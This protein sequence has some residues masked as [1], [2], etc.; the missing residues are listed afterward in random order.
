MAVHTPASTAWTSAASPQHSIHPVPLPVF[1]ALEAGDLELA[2]SLTPASCPPLPPFL[3]SAANR[4]IWRWRLDSIAADPEHA[5]W[6]S[7]LVVYSENQSVN[8]D[9]NCEEVVVGRI[10]FHGKPD[11]RGAVEV[12]YEID[13]EHRRKGHAR[14]ALR[15]MIEVARTIPEVK[16]FR[17]G[18]APENFVSRRVVEGAGLRHVCREVHAWRGLQ[19][20]FEI[21][22]SK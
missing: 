15:I 8:P 22:V 10:G 11:A 12:G 3:I 16:I 14:A 7:R 9:Q 19:D 1:E 4:G 20:V 21:D 13:S 2:S 18:I 6:M 5:P 17:A